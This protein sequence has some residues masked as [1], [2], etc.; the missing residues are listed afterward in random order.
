MRWLRAEGADDDRAD[1]AFGSLMAAMPR[2]SPSAGFAER[3]MHAVSPAS[4]PAFAWGWKVALAAALTLAGLATALIPA[5]R[6]V[7]VEPP[8]LATVAKALSDATGWVVE[9]I[10]GGLQVWD[11]MARV[12]QAVA[13]AMATPEATAALVGSAI[14][15]SIA[16]YTLNRLLTLER[17]MVG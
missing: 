1:Q 8:R 7:P 16:L 14:L 2:L 11:V 12:G 3:V 10:A 5:L 13:T 17:R 15:G 9:W 6:L 4:A